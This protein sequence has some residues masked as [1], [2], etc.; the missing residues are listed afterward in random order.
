MLSKVSVVWVVEMETRPEC[1]EEKNERRKVKMVTIDHLY[2]DMVVK[3]IRN[4]VA[5]GMQM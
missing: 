2:R 4:E 3:W 1:V 5:G